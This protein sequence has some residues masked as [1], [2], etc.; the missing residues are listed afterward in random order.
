MQRGG[1]SA[2]NSYVF[3]F[4]DFTYVSVTFF[5]K[6]KKRCSNLYTAATCR[7]VDNNFET[8]IMQN[9]GYGI[10]QDVTR[11][12]RRLSGR[13][14]SELGLGF[15]WITSLASTGIHRSTGTAF[16]A[17]GNSWAGRFIQ[18]G[19]F[20]SRTTS[21]PLRT[22]SWQHCQNC[23]RAFHSPWR[24]AWAELCCQW[25]RCF[26]GWIR[27]FIASSWGHLSRGRASIWAAIDA[28][29][30]TGF[31]GV[32]ALSGRPGGECCPEFG[33]AVGGAG[34]RQREGAWA[35]LWRLLSED[36][37]FWGAEMERQ[38]RP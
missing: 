5:I 22:L 32:L 18:G 12:W 25:S 6:L 36:A 14:S 7:T 17:L 3:R 21:M 11:G 28:T 1:I 24:T 16:S 19:T 31:G 13:S 8:T 29:W 33:I 26:F 10:D 4:N 34:S 30:W 37:A 2:Q 27:S 9:Q 35:H 38:V 15:R 23:S 20:C